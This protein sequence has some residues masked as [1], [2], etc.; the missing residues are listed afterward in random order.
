MQLWKFRNRNRVISK[1][2]IFKVITVSLC[3]LQLTVQLTTPTDMSICLVPN[4]DSGYMMPK[5]PSSPGPS[6]HGRREEARD[7]AMSKLAMA[8]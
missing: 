2:V 3:T 6:L 7:E 5:L 4:D 8:I 1:I